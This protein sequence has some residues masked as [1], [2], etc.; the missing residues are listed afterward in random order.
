MYQSKMK[1]LKTGRFALSK[2]NWNYQYSRK[3]N[4]KVH[5][6]NELS[7]ENVQEIVQG[8]FLKK[9]WQFYYWWRHHGNSSNT[10]EEGLLTT[11][12][13]EIEEFGLGEDLIR[14]NL[15]LWNTASQWKRSLTIW[16]AWATTLPNCTPSSSINCQKTIE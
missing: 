9:H 5:G 2:A 16:Y 3:N 7:V 8:I 11:Y 4:F 15:V 6:M 10:W 1:V 14:L 13:G 12:L